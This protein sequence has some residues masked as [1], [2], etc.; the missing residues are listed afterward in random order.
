METPHLSIE[1]RESVLVTFLY[2]YI[3]LGEHIFRIVEWRHVLD[4]ADDL[5]FME[6]FRDCSPKIS[7]L[8]DVRVMAQ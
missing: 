7:I 1:L 5:V 8:V 2:A 6:Y 4:Y 3:E